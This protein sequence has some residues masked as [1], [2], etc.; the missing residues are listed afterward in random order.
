MTVPLGNSEFCFPV[1]IKGCP[2][3]RMPETRE[4][5]NQDTKARDPKTRN[6]LFCVR[7]F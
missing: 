6:D 7:I 2:K 4:T 5:W 1:T 3:T